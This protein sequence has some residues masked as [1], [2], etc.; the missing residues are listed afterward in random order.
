[1]T[2][3]PVLLDC[4]PGH[5]DAIAILLAARYADLKAIT[6]VAGNVELERTTANALVTCQVYGIDV[7]VHPG[8]RTPLVVPHHEH[9]PQIH[10]E[11]GL[12]GPELPEL[13]RTPATTTAVER[14]L[15]ESRRTADLWVVATGPLTNV[16]LALRADPTLAD[17]L[18]GI[19][20]MGGGIGF[21]NVT[22]A[23]EFNIWADPHAAAIVVDAGIPLRVA[24]LDVTHQVLVDLPMADRV[25][26]LD[27]PA[28]RFTA[29]LFRHFAT[30]YREV[31]FEDAHGPLHDPC[32]VL[33][34]THPELF[35]FESWRLQI[36]TDPGVARGAMLADRRRVKH[37]DPPNAEVAMGVDADAVLRM[38]T[39]AV[40]HVGTDGRGSR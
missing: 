23:A 13:T 16:A 19:S 1:M 29:D 5:D 8:A 33:A 20:L 35:T 22:P 37:A 36:A 34:V 11:S 14:I 2:R 27:T 7:D 21:G 12:E 30:A 4:D 40:E 38:V 32:A 39:D 25:A 18:A 6:T 15:E 17:R 9:F 10:G 31:F 26:A 24:P 3:V 28:A